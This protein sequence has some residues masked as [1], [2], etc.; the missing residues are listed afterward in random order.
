MG[1]RRSANVAE[2][3]AQLA[4]LRRARPDLYPPT[5]HAWAALPQR[6]ELAPPLLCAV[7]FQRTRPGT[8]DLKVGSNAGLLACLSCLSLVVVHVWKSQSRAALCCVLPAHVSRLSP[9]LEG[10][11]RLACA[12]GL[13]RTGMS[14]CPALLA[15]KGV[16]GA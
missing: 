3:A 12:L 14:W 10:R 7:C 5:P 11:A 16:A 15:C 6:E 4:E 8:A 13:I 2:A 1:Q 9:T